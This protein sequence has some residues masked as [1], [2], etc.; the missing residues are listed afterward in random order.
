MNIKICG[1]KWIMDWQHDEVFP[2]GVVFI[3]ISPLKIWIALKAKAGR[4]KRHQFLRQRMCNRKWS[5]LKL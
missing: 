4:K 3:A 2:A 5:G 1:S